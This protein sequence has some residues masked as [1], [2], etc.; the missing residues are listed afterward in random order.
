MSTPRANLKLKKSVT[1]YLRM[2]S[3]MTLEQNSESYRATVAYLRSLYKEFGHAEVRKE[4][5]A[6]KLAEMEQS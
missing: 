6:R 5:H 2:L 1:R 3:T 4:I